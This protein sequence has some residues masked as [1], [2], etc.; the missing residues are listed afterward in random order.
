MS[1]VICDYDKNRKDSSK[2]AGSISTHFTFGGAPSVSDQTESP[3]GLPAGEKVDLWI[4]GSVF[5]YQR[6][7]SGRES[8]VFVNSSQRYNLTLDPEIDC[9]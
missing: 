8:Q 1:P 3:S 5:V 2:S 6:W 4:S 9:L 7:K